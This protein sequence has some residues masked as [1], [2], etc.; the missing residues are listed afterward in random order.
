M[1]FGSSSIQ[2]I[3]SGDFSVRGV[4]GCKDLR[5]KSLN[6]RCL[7]YSVASSSC[8]SGEGFCALGT[9]MSN[10]SRRPWPFSIL[11][12]SKAAF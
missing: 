9:E 6:L 2:S 5:L 7:R 4:H 8:C 12:I 1:Q 3:R 11:K 10:R